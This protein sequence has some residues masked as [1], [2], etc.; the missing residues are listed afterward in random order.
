MKQSWTLGLE[1]DIA[2]EIKGDFK[3]SLLVR[4]RL[5][6]LLNDKIT[7][8]RRALVNKE[9]YEVANWAYKQADGIGYERALQ[10]VI[11]LI[12]EDK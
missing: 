3:S 12:L 6:V 7:S 8:S 9:G 5:A 4:N 10:E 2:K 1:P 11:S